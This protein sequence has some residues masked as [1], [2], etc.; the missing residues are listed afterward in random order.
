MGQFV[1]MAKRKTFSQLLKLNM[2][3]ALSDAGVFLDTQNICSGKGH[4]HDFSFSFC[5]LFFNSPR[6]VVILGGK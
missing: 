2:A 6:I 4:P 3:L 1:G 5:F